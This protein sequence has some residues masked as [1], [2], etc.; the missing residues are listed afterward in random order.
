MN[1]FNYFQLIAY[2]YNGVFDQIKQ[3]SNFEMAVNQ[4]EDDSWLYPE[5]DNRLSNLVV[6]I[7]FLNI[8]YAMH[9]TFTAKQ[10]EVYKNQLELIK[11]D[12]LSVWLAP[13][14]LEHFNETV[15]L[16][17]YEIETFLQKQ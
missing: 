1:R 11:D 15:F 14:E 9:K 17:N 5:S 4:S 16:L 12:D 7:H 10:I 8:K 3:G 6:F 13:E 2:F